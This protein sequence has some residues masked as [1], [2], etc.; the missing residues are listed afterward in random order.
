MAAPQIAEELRRATGV[1]LCGQSVRN[2]L[3]SANLRARR[4]LTAVPLTQRHRQSRLA[5]AN[6][7]HHW[8]QRQWNEVLFT[9]E[10]RFNVDFADGRVCVWRRR[11]E[12]YD[13]ENVIQ[14][15]R[16]GGG[17]VMVWGG[18]SQRG[19][20]DLVTINGTLNSQR[21]C[22]EIVVPVVVPFLRRGNAG[23]FQQ[24]NARPH[25]ARHTQG[26]LHQNN[27]DVLDWPARSPDLSPIEHVWD[28]LGRRL[29]QRHNVN[30]VAE[31]TLALQQELNQITMNEIRTL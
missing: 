11:N 4:P 12:R 24:D 6:A 1:R 30:N 7:H 18:I 2:R 27:V 17:S 20:T 29:R 3:R 16:Y 26:I 13:Q 9:D 22:N 19:K 14:R 31:L 10:S 21:Y 8:I 15:D 23:I 5:W 25:T 28:I